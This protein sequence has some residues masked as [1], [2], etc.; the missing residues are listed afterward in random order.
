MSE[1]DVKSELRK[2]FPIGLGVRF[3]WAGNPVT[4]VVCEADPDWEAMHAPETRERLVW[5][6]SPAVCSGKAVPC[7]DWGVEAIVPG[8]EATP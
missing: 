6:S 3:T 5:V 7:G 2:R 4:G 8:E 1:Q